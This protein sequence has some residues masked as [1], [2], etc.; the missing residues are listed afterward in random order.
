LW[1]FPLPKK[2]RLK[3]SNICRKAINTIKA[4]VYNSVRQLQLY[5]ADEQVTAMTRLNPEHKAP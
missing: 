2:K 5:T 4:A 1:K 3:V